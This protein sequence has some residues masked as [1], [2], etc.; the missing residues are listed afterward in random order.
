VTDDKYQ[1][2]IGALE[3]REQILQEVLSGSQR[4]LGLQQLQPKTCR[5]P[6]L[7]GRKKMRLQASK[8]PES[9]FC[10]DLKQRKAPGLGSTAT[11][12]ELQIPPPPL[13]SLSCLAVER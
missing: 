5:V 8:K 4:I 6:G 13:S 11:I 9:A 2:D 1:D 12:S 3:A 7:Q 10:S